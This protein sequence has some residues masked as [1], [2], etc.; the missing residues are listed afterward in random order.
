MTDITI[1]HNPR[2]SKSRQTLALLEEKGHNPEII[3]YLDSAPT[4]TTL[5]DITSKLGVPLIDIVRTGEAAFNQDMLDWTE[6]KL[7]EAIVANPILMQRPI[8]LANGKARIGRPPESVL[9][10]L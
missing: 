6:A 9:E 8:V 3:L 1:Y 2:C 7:I 5:R 4:P 10:I